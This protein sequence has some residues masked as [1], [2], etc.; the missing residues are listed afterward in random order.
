[1][2]LNF[3][4]GTAA[5][6]IK[7]YP[8]I[9][10]ARDRGHKV[11]VIA[12]GQSRENFLMQYRDFALPESEL[13]NLLES[14]GDLEN[15]GSAMRWF[16][17][18]LFTPLKHF[19]ELLLTG[20]K[21]FLVVHG[22]TLSTLAG[23]WLGRK[24]RIPV[25]HI[26]AGLRSTS[27]FNP[28][29]EEITRRLVSRLAA[30]HMAPDAAAENNLRKA[31]VK[32]TIVNTGGNTLLDAVL[33]SGESGKNALPSGPFALVNVH[34]FENLNSVSRWRVI[35]DTVVKAA[36]KL[37]L[38]FVTHPQTRAKLQVDG[39][40]TR[41]LTE[42]AIEIRDRMPFSA[43]IALLKRAQFLISD[44]GSNQEECSY[45][46]KPCLLL[47]EATERHEGLDGCC[48]LSRFD[49][50]VIAGFLADPQRF[51]RP[52]IDEKSS[53]TGKILDHLSSGFEK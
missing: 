28:F 51:Q 5:E 53:P 29:P 40:S 38:V 46:G 12:S 17:R 47:R 32:G 10:L 23:A 1:M 44:G 13:V 49:S 11:R 35:V 39:E 8:L 4:T 16:L 48:V 19:R 9:H 21:S 34:R 45:L 14:D 7:L 36:G 15:A 22:D 30:I 50:A 27:L 25:V 26:E 43:F 24:A 41:L 52:A 18:A 2:Q 33:L 31:G 6:L 20:D 3:F 37:P 42:A